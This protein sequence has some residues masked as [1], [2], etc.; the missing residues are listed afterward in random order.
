MIPALDRPPFRPRFPWLTGNLQSLATVLLPAPKEVAPHARE[1][2]RL[3]LPDGDI[4]HATL[5]RPVEPKPGRPTVLLIHG[6]GGS[7]GSPYMLRASRQMLDS[8]HRV[9]RLNLRGAGPS[10]A[11]CRGQYYAG[12]S[13]DLGALLALLPGSLA[14]D[15]L[16]AVGY[17]V[18]GAI[19]LKYLGE[20]G[21]D[22]P[23]A[24]AAS[25]SAPIDL[26]ATCRN[27]MR[28]C[29]WLSHFMLLRQMKREA[30][31]PGAALTP[32]ERDGIRKA[33]TLW[34]FDEQFTA[35]RNGFA[36]VADYYARCSAMEFLGGIR[37][38][39]LVVA[40]QDDP[41]VPC[42]AYLGQHW[43]AYESLCLL[44]LLPE[45]GGH[46]GFHGVGSRHPWSD[47]AVAGFL[48]FH[49]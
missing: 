22:T 7:A 23:L 40:A 27:L 8:G 37:I 12:G 21:Q 2:L 17:S 9:V 35:P 13:A 43:S 28:P 48:A 31:G 49:R 36:D 44:P 16:V 1:A 42:A 39:T 6:A 33:R 38:P 26:A 14:T 32:A 20:A 41:W 45:Q 30:L 5:D 46:V 4:L 24:A 47:R 34:Q 19:L 15:G 11:D 10:R 25:V 18:G 3:A 29:N